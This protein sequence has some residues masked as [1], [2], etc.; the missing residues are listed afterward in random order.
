MN[1]TGS[2]EV[3]KIR[4]G[5]TEKAELA[6]IAVTEGRTFAGQCR[7]ALREWLGQKIARP[8]RGATAKRQ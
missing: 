2:T 4:L 6:R 5:L 8:G 3:V 7:Q 1:K